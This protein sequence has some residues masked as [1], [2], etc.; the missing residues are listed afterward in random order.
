MSVLAIIP[1]FVIL[2]G[3]VFHEIKNGKRWFISSTLS[4]GTYGIA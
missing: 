3:D 2:S 1:A 4:F